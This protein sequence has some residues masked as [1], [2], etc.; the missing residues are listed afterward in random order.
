MDINTFIKNK[1]RGSIPGKREEVE[2]TVESFSAKSESELLSDLEKAKQSGAINENSVN[3]FMNR[4]GGF[5][6]KEQRKK[7]ESLLKNLNK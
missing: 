4:F 2:K 1:G 6:T 7:A 5:L 3:D